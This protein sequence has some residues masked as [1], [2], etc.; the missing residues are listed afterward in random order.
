[1]GKDKWENLG[2]ARNA[3]RHDAWADL[4]ERRRGERDVDD[5]KKK[6]QG[7]EGHG[8]CKGVCKDVRMGDE[9]RKKDECKCDEKKCDEKKK[10]DEC[11]CDKGKKEKDMCK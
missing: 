1:M 3:R 11:K 10:K 8:A 9:K 4:G 2:E 5:E 7:R 6:K